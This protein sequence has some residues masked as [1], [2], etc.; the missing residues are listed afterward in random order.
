MYKTPNWTSRDEMSEIE[1]LQRCREKLRNID[2]VIS[3]KSTEGIFKILLR[4][5]LGLF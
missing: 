3:E 1:M 2:G 4:K 5:M